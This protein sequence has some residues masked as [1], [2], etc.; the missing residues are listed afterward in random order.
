MLQRFPY[1]Q[2]T[3]QTNNGWS[4]KE[5]HEKNKWEERENQIPGRSSALLQPPSWYAYYSNVSI[6]EFII[7]RVIVSDAAMIFAKKRLGHILTT[8]H[9][10]RE[11]AKRWTSG[12]GASRKQLSEAYRA[13]QPFATTKKAA[14]KKLKQSLQQNGAV[15]M[16]NQPT[17][18]DGNQGQSRQ[19]NGAVMDQSDDGDSEASDEED[20]EDEV[21]NSD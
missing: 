18:I 10:Q 7:D 19:Q 15:N 20:E 11:Y 5:I 1:E 8:E 3:L 9:L 2:R 14:K 4:Q 17:N 12:F 16:M 6:Q 13:T 21:V